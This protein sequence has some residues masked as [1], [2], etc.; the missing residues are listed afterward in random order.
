MDI[1]SLIGIALVTVL[2][3]GAVWLG[4]GSYWLFFD[5][6]A[7]LMVFGG[8]GA[9]VLMGLPLRRIVALPQLLRKCLVRQP[10]DHGVLID[11]LVRLAE[12]ARREGLLALETRPTEIDEPLLRLGLQLAVDGTRPEVVEEILRTEITMCGAR[13][14]EGKGTLDQFGRSA[15]AFGLIGT[16]LGLVIMLH[17]MWDP[18]TLGTGMAV[19]LLTTLYGAVAANACFLPFSEKLAALHREEALGMEIIVRGVL[20]I[21]SGEHPRVVRRKLV[22]YLPPGQRPVESDWARAA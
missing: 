22:T 5:Y 4:G 15:P 11:E 1:G 17:N 12:I 10:Q 9:A 16:L 13:H 3:G 8:A 14:Q 6:R 19:A 18:S 20:A 2:L 7:L 21:Q